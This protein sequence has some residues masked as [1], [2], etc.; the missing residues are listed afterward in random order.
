MAPTSLA[1]KMAATARRRVSPPRIETTAQLLQTRKNRENMVWGR[2]G[3]EA[4][5]AMAESVVVARR[6]TC[7]ALCAPL[8]AVT[9]ETTPAL[10][11]RG[12]PE[13]HLR[14]S[15]SSPGVCV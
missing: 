1:R 4:A 12:V 15:F 7:R 8:K 11:R 6:E 2:A 14:D 9:Q 5:D 13:N 10:E 3:T